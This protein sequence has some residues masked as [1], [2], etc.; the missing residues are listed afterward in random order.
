[1]LEHTF[2][3]YALE[4]VYRAFIQLSVTVTENK[5]DKCVKQ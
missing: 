5:N 2:V 3:F 4:K 1:M